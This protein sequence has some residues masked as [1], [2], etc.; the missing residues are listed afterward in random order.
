M[1]S[2]KLTDMINDECF[3]VLD[4][5]SYEDECGWGEES[6]RQIFVGKTER[7]VIRLQYAP[8]Y[9]RF[10]SNS[11]DSYVFRRLLLREEMR[12]LW[13]CGAFDEMNHHEYEI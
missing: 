11:S 9:G 1:E 13:Y 10:E 7:S 5:R 6:V 12:P 3:V 4:G 2:S 8:N